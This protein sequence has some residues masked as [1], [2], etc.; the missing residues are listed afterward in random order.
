M[1][2]L[3]FSEAMR[4]KA[5]LR[6]TP[7]ETALLVGVLDNG[8]IAARDVVQ[9]LV[10]SAAGGDVSRPDR[11]FDVFRTRLN[12]KLPETLRVRAIYPGGA[13]RPS[14]KGGFGAWK[15]IGYA[16]TSEAGRDELLR[17]ARTAS[18]PQERAAA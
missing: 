9:D 1:S 11:C 8:P 4:L 5:A 13:T 17:V 3:T 18:I 14:R 6:L 2:E 7:A 10:R 16:L 15:A 12:A